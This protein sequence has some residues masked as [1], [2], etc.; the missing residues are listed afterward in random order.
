[1]IK[2]VSVYPNPTAIKWLYELLKEREPHQ[3]IS[4]NKLPSYE[5]HSKFVWSLP[6]KYWYLVYTEYHVCGSIYLTNQN[7]IGVW[8]FKKCQGHGGGLN[9]V[10]ELMKK[11]PGG[12]FLSNINPA[13]E[14]SIKMFEGLGFK[15]IQNT[16]E[17]TK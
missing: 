7:E 10:K 14:K 2:L 13:N 1:M 15:H 4:H 8:L 6:Y 9:A 12:R 11:H 3:S 17:Y 16:Y 5:D